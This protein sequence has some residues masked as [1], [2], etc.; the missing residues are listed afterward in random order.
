MIWLVHPLFVMVIC[1]LTSLSIIWLVFFIFQDLPEYCTALSLDFQP[2]LFLN[3]SKFRLN[4]LWFQTFKTYL[5]V[6]NS[7]LV[8]IYHLE[9]RSSW[10]LLWEN[11]VCTHAEFSYTG[12][13]SWNPE[14]SWDIVETGIKPIK[15]T[16]YIP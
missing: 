10:Q 2:G 5:R 15:S 14:Y 6:I 16:K 11:K 1:H 4:N 9:W 7:N 3:N 8:Y 13:V 12:L